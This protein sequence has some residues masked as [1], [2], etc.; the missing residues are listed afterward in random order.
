MAY[1]I[2]LN[3]NEQKE[4]I[5]RKNNQRDGKVLRRLGMTTK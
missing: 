4:L 2:S 1:K 3:I 5:E